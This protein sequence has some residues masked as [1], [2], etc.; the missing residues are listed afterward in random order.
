LIHSR[1]QRKQ[2]RDWRKPPAGVCLR[3][4]KPLGG[5]C[6]L[7]ELSGRSNEVASLKNSQK[8]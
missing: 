5:Y 7:P 8:S 2:T 3:P 6:P 1:F 4:L